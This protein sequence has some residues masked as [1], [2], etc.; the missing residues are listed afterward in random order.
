MM[1]LTLSFTD[2]AAEEKATGLSLAKPAVSS[3]VTTIF[4]SA[5]APEVLR[6]VALILA[7]LANGAAPS[8]TETFRVKCDELLEQFRAE[9]ATLH[10]S[11]DMSED[12]VYALC[13]LLDE[14][15]LN[16]LTGA[17]R[18]AWEHE[19]LQVRYFQTHD[20]GQ[21]L[22]ARIERRLAEPAPVL[23]LLAIFGDILELGFRGKFAL[24]GG[25]AAR[26]ALLHAIAARL[27][28]SH[29]PE[30]IS[31]DTVAVQAKPAAALRWRSYVCALSVAGASG[32][33]AAG[34]YSS[35]HYW[36]A[37]TLAHLAQH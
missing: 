13:A 19:P 30:E 32:L 3:K 17:A 12:A 23:S 28:N 27:H 10:Y 22:I 5:P 15:A 29:Q 21:A 6:D 4:V 14:A 35:L 37:T 11:N 2:F 36:L 24:Q 18:E 8:T 34:V 20:A 26:V 25:D 31:I 16:G 7:S 33:L 1:P 9:L